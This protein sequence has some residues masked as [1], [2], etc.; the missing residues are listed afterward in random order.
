MIK[1]QDIDFTDVDILLKENWKK[2]ND[3][4]DF[5]TNFIYYCK[6][7]NQVIDIA[8]CNDADLVMATHR[9]YN[10]VCSKA[11][12]EMF[13]EL[14]AVAEQNEK[15]K[16][17]DFYINNIPFD[18]KL[19]IVPNNFQDLDLTTRKNKDE[20]IK[21]LYANQSQE[22]RKHE[23][24]RIFVVCKGKTYFDSLWLK[25]QFETIRKKIKAFM[26]YTQTHNKFNEVVLDDNIT[27]LSDIIYVT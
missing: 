4:D 14:G 15:D 2:Q 8:E 18:L 1:Y 22:G 21:W 6:T 27:V 19:T 16:F 17:T 26:A 10:F 12:E 3:N 5:D 13:C 9:W 7:Y 23:R 24:N 11:V 20:L 25:H